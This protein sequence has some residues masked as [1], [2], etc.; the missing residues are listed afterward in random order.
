VPRILICAYACLKDPCTPLPGGG[1]LMA[2]KLVTRLS[3][4][5]ELW[6]LTSDLNR[7]AIEAA[8]PQVNGD[9]LHFCYV[10][11]PEALRPLL[12]FAGGVH[13]YAYLWQWRAY[14]TARRLQR[15]IGF[16][17]FHHL[18]YDNDWMASPTGALLPVPYLRGPGG[19]AHR[20]P[21]AFIRRYPLRGRL[22]EWFRSTMQWLLRHDPFFILGHSRAKLIL[23]CNRESFEALP[24]RWQAKAQIFPVN[25][26]DSAL[27]RVARPERR[28]GEFRVL[29]A[30][31]LVRLKAFDLGVRAFAAFAR[32]HKPE[33]RIVLQIIGT[34]PERERLEE[35]AV[36][37]GVAWRVRF[38]G[39]KSQP[40]LWE[41]MANAHVFLF[42]SLRDGGGMVVVEA[43]ATGCPVVCADLGGPAMHVT[44]ECGIKLKP[45][46]PE[47]LIGDIAQ[48]L[49]HLYRHPALR[50]AMGAAARRRTETVYSWD[51]L[52]ERMLQIYHRLLDV[53]P[54]SASEAEKRCRV[55]AL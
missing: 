28:D 40:E 18:T 53:P 33:E 22:W 1:D 23:V 35:L 24:R 2:W 44:P 9:R 26:V 34:G 17:L 6:V 48:A 41:A 54:G 38:E 21:K 11:L 49:E 4:R 47:Q 51:V 3:Q 7:E 55:K 16:D 39:W 42:P 46:T 14:C 25:G 36:E 13:F 32:Q 45:E 12:R 15:E 43:M 31:R 37:L 8:K 20:T 19:G 30:G 52:A 5:C 50:Q 27:L 10:G 29:M